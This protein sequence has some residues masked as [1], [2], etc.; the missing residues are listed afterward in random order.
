MILKKSEELQK[1]MDILNPLIEDDKSMQ[2]TLDKNTLIHIHESALLS[3][4][5]MDRIAEESDKKYSTYK[6][7]K[8]AK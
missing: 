5:I 8:K 2:I 1:L 3:K 4:M 6:L 7:I